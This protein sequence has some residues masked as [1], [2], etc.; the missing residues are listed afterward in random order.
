[1]FSDVKRILIEGY[2]EQLEELK[3]KE[4]RLQYLEKSSQIDEFTLVPVQKFNIFQKLFKSKSYRQYIKTMQ[5]A[6]K[7][8]EE[9]K[10]REK[11]ELKE[12][13]E[14]K[15]ERSKKIEN[16]LSKYEIVMSANGLKELG[17]D[18][19]KAIEILNR[20]QIPIRLEKS[21]NI[22]NP[23]R[24]YKGL[25]DLVFVHRTDRIIKNNRL[26]TEAEDSKQKLKI[27]F[28]G[29]EY[30]YEADSRK[31]T[32]QFV[33]NNEIQDSGWKNCKYTIVIPVKDIPKE[34]IEGVSPGNAY[35]IGGVDLT[36]NCYVL[37]KEE[38][39]EEL[40]RQNPQLALKNIIACKGN[41]TRNYSQILL[42]LL[43]Y[44]VEQPNSEF[45]YDSWKDQES[46]AMLRQIVE[47]NKID[48]RGYIEKGVDKD[49]SIRKIKAMLGIY[50][51]IKK[52]DLVRNPKEAEN[53]LEQMQMFQDYNE[54][55]YRILGVL[56]K[57]LEKIGIEIKQQ[58]Q[59]YFEQI[60]EMQQ[61]DQIFSFVNNNDN[62]SNKMKKFII[63]KCKE[64]T[65]AE[66]LETD[67][68]VKLKHFKSQILNKIIIDSIEEDREKEY[69][70]SID[71]QVSIN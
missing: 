41:S 69:M 65:E 29:K 52:N 14:G 9:K 31:D 61:L 26:T 70:D 16:I 36:K 6:Q 35:T 19:N 68:N 48:Y 67:E 58:E 15:E 37:C 56:Y 62:I 12:L 54:D 38:D 55:D 25:E 45:D 28:N 2:N 42:K 11:E 46:E 7:A 49:N 71:N 51:C 20:K 50:Q 22:D 21:D 59:Q 57:K 60:K 64:Y 40:R 30:E 63:S 47:K 24:N 34:I 33:V 18:F 27:K 1:M 53:I 13:L 23:E 32:L 39:A 44:R 66:N 4:D 8:K 43:G 17:I 3:R 10:K 5:L